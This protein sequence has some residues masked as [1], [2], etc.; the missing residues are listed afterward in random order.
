MFII[1]QR[2]KRTGIIYVYE[3]KSYWDKEKRQPRSNRTLIGK[4]DEETGEIVPTDGRGK[5]R[6]GKKKPVSGGAALCDEQK[7]QLKEKSLLISQLEGRNKELEEELVSVIK[8]IRSISDKYGE[9]R[10]PR[11]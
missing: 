3:S 6:T 8:E 2:D 9:R 11:P 1:K 7:R 4:L 10:Q 5:K